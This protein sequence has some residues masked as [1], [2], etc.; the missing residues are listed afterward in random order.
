MREVKKQIFNEVWFFYKKYALQECGEDAYWEQLNR[1]AEEI[2]K[3][4]SGDP[5][6]REL[7]G[8]VINELAKKE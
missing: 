5:F 7:I 1:D 3:K 8:V 2:V 4:H 6:A